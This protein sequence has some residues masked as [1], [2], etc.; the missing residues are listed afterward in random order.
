MHQKPNLVT[1][2]YSLPDMNGAQL[3]KKIKEYNNQILVIAISGQEDVGTAVELLK[4]GLQDY[5]VKDE[6]SKDLLWNAVVKARETHQLKNE[7]E[8][9]RNELEQKFDFEKSIKGNSPAIKRI[10]ALMEK[11]TKTNINVSITGETG[12]GKEV[13]AKAIHYNCERKKK[14]TINRKEY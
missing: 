1:I 2:D 9:L 13:V 7:I 11:A 14:A 3:L 10:F 6:N 5:I 4:M 8:Q 12:T